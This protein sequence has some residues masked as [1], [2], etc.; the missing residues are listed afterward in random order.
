MPHPGDRGP[1][2]GLGWGPAAAAPGKPW[3]VTRRSVRPP[4]PTPTHPPTPLP[5]NQQQQGN[6]PWPS[7]PRDSYELERSMPSLEKCE[8]AAST[9]QCCRFKPLP[10]PRPRKHIDLYHSI[11]RYS[12]LRQGNT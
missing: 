2:A 11:F 5:P 3:P 4:H 8:R 1:W 9:L 10:R 12:I 7:V 6:R